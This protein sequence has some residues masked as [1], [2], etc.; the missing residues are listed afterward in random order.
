MAERE[1]FDLEIHEKHRQ[2][3]IR[4]AEAQAAAAMAEAKYMTT[5]D[6]E[7]TKIQATDRHR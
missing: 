3:K 6:T 5:R 1:H 2:Q 4:L 7:K